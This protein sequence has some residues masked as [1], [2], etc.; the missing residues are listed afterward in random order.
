MK[1]ILVVDDE[2]DLLESTVDII[3]SIDFDVITATNGEEAITKFRE[4]MP[5]LVLM[6]IKMP[7]KDGFDAFFKIKEL[8]PNAK[9]ILI[10]GKLVDEEKLKKAKAIT[11]ILVV[12]KPYSPEFLKELVIRYS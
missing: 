8:N 11:L 9:I 5:D 1:T 6:D 4:K 7:K 10:T 12:Q 2:T 3:K